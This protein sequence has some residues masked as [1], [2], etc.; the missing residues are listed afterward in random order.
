MA[1]QTP[2]HSGVGDLLDYLSDRPL[3][4]GTLVRVPLGQREVLGLVWDS[5]GTPAP[6]ERSLRPVAA[7]LDG[8]APL[9][10][11][12]RRLVAF[13]ARYYQRSLGEVALSALPPQLRTLGPAQV[14]RRLRR[15]AAASIW[16]RRTR[17]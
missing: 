13:A 16:A 7:V 1:V 14:A 11:P 9:G 12:W 10:A 2:A 15:P 6:P 17:T 5:D 4:A 8:I 3:P